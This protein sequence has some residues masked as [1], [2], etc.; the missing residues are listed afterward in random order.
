[1]MELDITRLMSETEASDFSASIAERGANAGPDT[2]RNACAEG[3]D[4]PL[5]TSEADLDAAR[6]YFGEFGAWDD[7]ERAAWS[8]SEINGLLIQYISGNIREIESLCMGDD[9]AI[10]WSEVERQESEGR[11]A[12][13]IFRAADGRIY[14][15]MGS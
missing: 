5:L 11:I 1:M 3:A 12:G 10:D 13:N 14:F 4:N 9:G 6:D 15:Y 7:E 8:A 2:W